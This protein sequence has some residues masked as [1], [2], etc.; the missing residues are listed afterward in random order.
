[1]VGVGCGCRLTIVFSYYILWSW[2]NGD[3]R[4]VLEQYK[5]SWASYPKFTQSERDIPRWL[6]GYPEPHH[7]RNWESEA[8][9]SSNSGLIA[10]M[11]GI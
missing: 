5:K 11:E 3:L 10:N 2:A 1:M 9:K 8:V 6:G 7:K 4:H